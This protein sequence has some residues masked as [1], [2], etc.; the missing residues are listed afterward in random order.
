[1]SGAERVPP[2]RDLLELLAA[3]FDAAQLQGVLIGG[4]ARNLWSVPR[5]TYDIDFTVEADP[6]AIPEAIRR[7]V[8]GGYRVVKEQASDSRSGPDFVQLYNQATHQVVEF[9][10]AKTDFQRGVVERGVPIDGLGPLRV[11]TAEDLIVLKLIASRRKDH[12]DLLELAAIQ[13]LDWAYIEHWCGVWQIQDRLA[14]L[15]QLLEGPP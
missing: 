4:E 3:V 10:S 7:L 1:M 9:Q 13:G 8:D 6:V 14:W 15:R 12:D 2:D 5:L 11:A